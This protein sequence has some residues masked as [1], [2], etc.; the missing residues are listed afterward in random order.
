MSAPRDPREGSQYP[1]PAGY[2]YGQ[3]PGYGAPPARTR[4]GFGIAAL[5]LGLLALL[6][7]WTILGGIIFGI[8]ALIFGLLGRGRAKRGEATNGG[9]AIAGVV[10][11]VIGGLIAIG[12]IAIGVSLL[13]S[14][15]GRSY[16]QCVQ[17]SNYDPAKIEQCASEFVRQMGAG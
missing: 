16:Q 9:Q 1:P 14:P 5:L 15:A 7:C 13:N 3:D 12:L 17:Q 11:G 6:L 8:L 4:N 10:L 2:G